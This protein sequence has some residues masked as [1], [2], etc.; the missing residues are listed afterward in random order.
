[1]RR[2]TFL[3]TIEVDHLTVW[4]LECYLCMA[5]ASGRFNCDRAQ[6]WFDLVWRAAKGEEY[7]GC[8]LRA[9]DVQPGSVRDLAKAIN[10]RIAMAV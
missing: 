1:M 2:V 10:H 6:L 7:L 3:N 8:I 9:G 4:R 5:P